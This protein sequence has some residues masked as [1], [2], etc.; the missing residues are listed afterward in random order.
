MVGRTHFLRSA[1][2]DIRRNEAIAQVEDAE[3][4]HEIFEEIYLVVESVESRAWGRGVLLKSEGC[5]EG[6]CEAS[7]RNEGER[8][9]V[10]RWGEGDKWIWKVIRECF[11]EVAGVG[12]R[13][14]V[15]DWL[16]FERWVMKRLILAIR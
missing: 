8:E 7:W 4:K 1:F 12:R 16:K 10:L 3:E 15:F 2:R 13:G 9:S 11:E 5:R 6:V 14:I